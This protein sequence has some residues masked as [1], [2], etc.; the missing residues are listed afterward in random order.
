MKVAETAKP[1]KNLDKEA[2]MNINQKILESSAKEYVLGKR[3]SNHENVG[4]YLGYGQ[5]ADGDVCILMEYIDG[6]SLKDFVF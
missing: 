6:L 3:C 5:D 2:R 4:K 1:K